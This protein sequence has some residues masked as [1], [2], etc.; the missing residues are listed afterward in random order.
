MIPSPTLKE[1]IVNNEYF[2]NIGFSKNDGHLSQNVEL[3]VTLRNVLK[4]FDTLINVKGHNKNKI[5]NIDDIPVTTLKELFVAEFRILNGDY[6]KK[7]YIIDPTDIPATTLKQM[8]INNKHILN[9]N[10]TKNNGYLSQ[11]I[12]LLKTLR[13]LLKSFNVANLQGFLKQRNRSAEKNMDIDNRKQQLLKTRKPTN[14]NYNKTPNKM[15]IGDIEF[16]NK[17]DNKN[18][19]LGIPGIITNERIN[20]NYRLKKDNNK[21]REM[22]KPVKRIY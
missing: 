9:V 14:S 8:L 1:L 22:I 17:T 16:N 12:K 10:F 18:Y 7:N 21:T 11:N 19:R 4:N 5:F 15:N 20:S 2:R 13:N 3:G 6:V